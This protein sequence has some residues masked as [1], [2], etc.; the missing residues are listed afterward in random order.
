MSTTI[1]INKNALATIISIITKAFILGYMY[2]RCFYIGLFLNFHDKFT[3]FN[4]F[5]QL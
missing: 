5:F 2:C 4:I 1:I 3:G